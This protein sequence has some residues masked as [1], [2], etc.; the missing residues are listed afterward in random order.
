MV[1]PSII[2][3][4]SW[5][6]NNFLEKLCRKTFP[7][8]VLMKSVN[9]SFKMKSQCLLFIILLIAIKIVLLLRKIAVC[10]M[11]SSQPNHVSKLDHG[12][13]SSF[14]IFRRKSGSFSG[15]ATNIC[16]Y[17]IHDIKHSS[18]EKLKMDELICMFTSA[19]ARR[20]SIILRKLRHK[21]ET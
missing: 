8:L 16:W 13:S 3:S 14:N 17:L 5:S 10:L 6:E 19:R 2:V 7:L 20:S 15:T 11:M 18:Q 1:A 21:K 12:S 4:P 9:L